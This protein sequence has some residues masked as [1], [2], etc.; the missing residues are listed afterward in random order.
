M[1]IIPLLLK[2]VPIQNYRLQLTYSDG[3]SCEINLSQWVGKGVFASWN[4]PKAFSQFVI[5]KSRKLVWNDEIDL[6]PDA[7]YLEIIGKTFEEYARDK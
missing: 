4:N 1:R 2:A 3:Q 6:D 5:D 7:F